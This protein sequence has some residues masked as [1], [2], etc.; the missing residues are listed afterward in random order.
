MKKIQTAFQFFVSVLMMFLVGAAGG[1]FACAADVAN[2]TAVNDLGGGKGVVAEGGSSVTA[3]EKIQDAEWY[4]KQIDKTI[5]EM[6]F[7]GTPSS[8]T[9]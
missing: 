6:K 4:Q 3:N 8:I 7:T 9:A 1:G 2:G 5:V